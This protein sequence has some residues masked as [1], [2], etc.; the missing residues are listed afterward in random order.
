M[1]RSGDVAC[2]HYHR[3]RDDIALMKQLGLKAY[4]FS[5]AWPRIYPFGSGAVNEEGLRFYDELVDALLDAG[6]EPMA[7]LYHWDLPQSLQDQGGWA[8][9]RDR[10]PL[11]HLRPHHVR[12]PWRPGGQM[13]HP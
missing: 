5:I 6:I 13:G 1:V 8:E 7:T 11:R 10:H 2:D 9:P 12:P 3:F 4:R